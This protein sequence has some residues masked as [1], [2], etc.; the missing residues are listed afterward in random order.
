MKIQRDVTERGYSMEK[1]LEQ[2]RVR[3]KDYEKHIFK[4]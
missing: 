1:V 4:W 2:I 3:E